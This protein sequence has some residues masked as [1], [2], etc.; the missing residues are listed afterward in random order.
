MP[1][2]GQSQNI[3]LYS[4]EKRLWETINEARMAFVNAYLFFLNMFKA[5]FF[6]HKDMK[7]L[8]LLASSSNW[9]S[10]MLNQ[11]CCQNNQYYIFSTIFFVVDMYNMILCVYFSL[12]FLSCIIELG[13]I[14][15]SIGVRELQSNAS[16]AFAVFADCHRYITYNI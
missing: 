5:F 9:R 3:S 11:M 12:S 1:K 8:L 14:F 15:A 16:E 4:E 13:D 6:W 7:F 2:H 10:L